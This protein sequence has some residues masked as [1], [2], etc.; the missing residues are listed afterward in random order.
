MGRLR[1]ARIAGGLG[2]YYRGGEIYTHKVEEEGVADELR[3]GP[4]GLK[5][6]EPVADLIKQFAR[7]CAETRIERDTN[8]NVYSR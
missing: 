8:R 1:V 7:I 3:Y 4:N 6:P 2:L 5:L